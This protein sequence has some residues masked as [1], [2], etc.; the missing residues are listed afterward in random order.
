[1]LIYASDDKRTDKAPENSPLQIS[2]N[3][4]W[5]NITIQNSNDLNAIIEAK[6]KGCYFDNIL[7]NIIEDNSYF[8]SLGIKGSDL[9]HR[10]EQLKRHSAY[11][12]AFGLLILL[13]AGSALYKYRHAIGNKVQ[14]FY[15][16]L[17]HK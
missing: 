1:M 13:A 10:N 11:R 5:P 15:K 3:S 6:P 12:V 4:S 14:N 17:A 16:K 7:P 9:W 8:V 2:V